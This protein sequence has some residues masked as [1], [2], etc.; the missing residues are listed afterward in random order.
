MTDKNS[1]SARMVYFVCEDFF[2]KGRGYRVSI[3]K[4]GESG[5]FPTGTWPYSGGIDE[6]LPYFCGPTLAE[7][8][9]RV[10]ALKLRMGIN[11]RDA[12]L[13]VASSMA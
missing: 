3:V 7:A 6:K 4:G 5:H 2:V 13:I 11:A 1:K 10:D 12:A 8:Q 9:E